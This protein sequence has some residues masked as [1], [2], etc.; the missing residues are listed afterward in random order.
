M[1]FAILEI[2]RVPFIELWRILRSRLIARS[3]TLSRRSHIFNGLILED[4]SAKGHL[5]ELRIPAR[6]QLAIE[7][8]WTL[9]VMYDSFFVGSSSVRS[10]A[11]P[12]EDRTSGVHA[13]PRE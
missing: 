11:A 2:A 5:S 8:H 9:V 7:G 4:R 13:P 12:S 1:Q 3:T 6:H 10:P